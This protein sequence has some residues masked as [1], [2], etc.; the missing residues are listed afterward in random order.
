MAL[1]ILGTIKN[2]DEVLVP[3]NTYIASVLSVSENGLKPIFIEPN[4][5][6]YNINPD[7]IEEKITAKT[8]SLISSK[9]DIAQASIYPAT[10]PP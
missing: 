7:L 6:T 9:P 4:I 10:I 3:A 1:K 8:T 5:D 2:H